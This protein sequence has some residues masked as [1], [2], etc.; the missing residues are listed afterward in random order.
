MKYMLSQLPEF[1]TNL[2]EI[3]NFAGVEFREISKSSKTYSND[4]VSQIT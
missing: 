3:S 4:L 1:R 2:I